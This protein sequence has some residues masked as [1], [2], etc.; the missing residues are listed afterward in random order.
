M[1]TPD[2]TQ[3]LNAHS[4][5]RGILCNKQK[6]NAS[7]P[8][9]PLYRRRHIEAFTLSRETLSQFD[10]LKAHYNSRSELGM[11]TERASVIPRADNLLLYVDI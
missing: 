10:T 1:A 9:C 11:A 2:Q 7:M 6:L 8:Q 3:C 4:I 5:E